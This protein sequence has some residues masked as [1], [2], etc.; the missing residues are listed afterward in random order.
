VNSPIENPIFKSAAQAV[1]F[2]YM[3]HGLPVRRTSGLQRA[4]WQA[5]EGLGF[6]EKVAIGSINFNGLDDLEVRGQCAMIRLHVETL[7]HKLASY[8]L[9]SK[10]GLTQMSEMNGQK[11]M[12]FS[13]EKIEAM[14]ALTAILSA[15]FD[16]LSQTALMLLIAR[17]CADADSLK[18]TLREIAKATSIS[19]ST[20]FRKEADVAKAV[21]KLVA[22]GLDM[23]EPT[24]RKDG[25]IA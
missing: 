7:P 12:A 5:T 19:K 15:Q 11:R 16:G 3:M 9:Q 10:F 20:L 18:P 8:A 25:L 17:C 24:W 14:R 1:F 4:I 2:A 21:F 6:K 22:L 23:L 13:P